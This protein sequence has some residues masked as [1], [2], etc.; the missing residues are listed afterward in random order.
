LFFYSYNNT[1]GSGQTLAGLT[2]DQQIY[3]IEIMKNI[4]Y[5]KS[6]E[7]EE[8]GGS[9]PNLK[10]LKN[11]PKSFTD[12]LNESAHSV[13]EYYIQDQDSTSNSSTTSTTTTSISTTPS[14][15][16][17]FSTSSSSSTSEPKTAITSVSATTLPLG[18]DYIDGENMS[19]TVT[20][21]STVKALTTSRSSTILFSPLDP[22]CS[23]LVGHQ[24][25][26]EKSKTLE[27]AWKEGKRATDKLLELLKSPIIDDV[28]VTTQPIGESSE[29]HIV[30]ENQTQ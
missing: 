7:Q 30:G 6:R 21:S 8:E 19:L 20:T 17:S 14:I 29:T 24:Q 4:L 12:S 18:G 27:E 5:P 15:D 28:A 9:I 16:K 22:Y 1:V 10:F 26:D 2:K 13:L 11:L 3:M 23:P 25:D